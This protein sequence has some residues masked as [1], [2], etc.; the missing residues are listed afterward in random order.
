[1][2][3]DDWV[4]SHFVNDPDITALRDFHAMPELKPRKSM[5]QK[6]QERQELRDAELAY[7]TAGGCVDYRD[8]A[9]NPIETETKPSGK[10]PSCSK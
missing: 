2:T 9:G 7:V 4:I 1:M 5:T 3:K 10:K 6:E 8:N